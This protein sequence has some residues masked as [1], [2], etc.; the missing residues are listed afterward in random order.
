MTFPRYQEEEETFTILALK[1][2]EIT[3]IIASEMNNYILPD[4]N[5]AI[6]ITDPKNKSV[7][8]CANTAA[9]FT[10]KKR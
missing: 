3:F 8:L 1:I 5:I 7:T 10:S 9:V 4:A 6:I 2:E